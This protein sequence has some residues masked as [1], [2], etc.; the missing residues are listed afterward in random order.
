M[1]HPN[2]GGRFRVRAGI[3]DETGYCTSSFTAHSEILV[4]VKDDSKGKGTETP[5]SLD[6]VFPRRGP[7]L[8]TYGDTSSREDGSVLSVQNTHSLIN[9]NTSKTPPTMALV[10]F[11]HHNNVN[12]FYRCHLPLCSLLILLFMI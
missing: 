5:P 6:T 12:V 10:V 1:D 4:H 9:F 3:L 2:R 8:G 7:H 11:Y